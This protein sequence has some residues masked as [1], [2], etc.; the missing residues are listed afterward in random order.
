MLRG[1]DDEVTCVVVSSELNTV[2]SGSRDGTAILFSLHSGHY[3]RTIPHP[4][5]ASVDLV[6]LSS[7]GGIAVYSLHDQVLHS[8]TMNHRHSEPPLASVGAGERLAALCF[9][10]TGE[11][12]L[13]A[14]EQGVVVLRH[15]HTLAVLH[16]L[17]ASSAESPGGSGP[18]RCLALSPGEEYVLAGSQRG[19]LL[20]WA[21]PC[22]AEKEVADALEHAFATPLGL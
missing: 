20:V 12:L 14:G 6:A 2:L 3:V 8:C 13:S 1:H 5:A 21:L 22:P 9:N 18:L 17:R 16:E 7:I 11:V 4:S 10:P 15:P 19:S